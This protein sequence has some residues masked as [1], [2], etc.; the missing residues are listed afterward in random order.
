MPGLLATY[1]AFALLTAAAAIAAVPKVGVLVRPQ[2][3]APYEA[4]LRDG[5]RELGYVEGRNIVV[6]WR[7][8]AG[9][10]EDAAVAT[11][12]ARSNLD[13]VV[14]FS[15]PGARAAMEANGNVPIV[16]LSGDPVATGLAVSLSR[17]GKNATG[18]TG[19]MTELTGKRMEL[20]RQ[21]VPGVRRIICLANPGNPASVLQCEAAK[22]G[23][24]AL[25]LQL[26]TVSA[27]NSAELQAAVLQ[28]PRGTKNAL[29][30]TADGLFLVNKAKIARAARDHKLPATFPLRDYH[31]DGALMSYGL[32]P[33][34]VGR[35][36]AT[37]VDKILKGANAGDI[38]VEQISKYELIIDMRVA[39][40]LGLDVPQTL[41]LQAD[42]ILK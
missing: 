19:V 17:P 37:Y 34:E 25:G 38:P 8:S 20:L 5:L 27:R 7:R 30:V 13:V 42:Q 16:F 24:R 41:L 33:H 26:S 36:V 39:R 23:A 11:S 14:V 4:G 1:A 12:L 28:L 29:F 18:V 35:K 9:G 6:D 21:L 32:N 31:E 2:V 3:S 40:E 22:A 10:D 15:T